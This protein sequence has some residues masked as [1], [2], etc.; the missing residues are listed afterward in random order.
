MG[1]QHLGANLE[2]LNRFTRHSDEHGDSF[3]KLVPKLEEAQVGQE[4]FGMMPGS[5]NIYSAY[6]DRVGSCLDSLKS[7]AEAVRDIGELVSSCGENY[8][9]IDTAISEGLD[10]I[11]KELRE[12]TS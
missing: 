7:C 10:E 6:E 9:N 4:S 3:D 11:M 5:G 12:G 1:G 8:H 2:A